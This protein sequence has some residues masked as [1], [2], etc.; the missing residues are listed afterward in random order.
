MTKISVIVPAKNEEANLTS[1]LNDLYKTIRQLTGY[2]VEVICVDDHSTDRTRADRARGWRYEPA[3]G[4]H[5]VRCPEWFQG[6]S[7]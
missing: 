3:S 7:A 4:R 5:P 1:V 2:E 6:F